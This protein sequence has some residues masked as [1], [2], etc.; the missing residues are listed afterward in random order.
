MNDIRCVSRLL[1]MLLSLCAFSAHAEQKKVF[2]GPEGSEYELHYIAL[3]S[4]FLEPEIA[5]QYQLIRSKAMGLINISL[6]QV[7]PDGRRKA[8]TALVQG[9]VTNEIQQQNVLD[10]K[11]VIEGDA[12]YYLSQLQFAEG[13]NLRIDLEVYPPGLNE[14]LVHRFTHAFFND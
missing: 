5:R 1:I 10:F 13:K 7:F 2:D 3:N 6:I 4:T 14:P 9:R 8:Q 12:V 11:Q